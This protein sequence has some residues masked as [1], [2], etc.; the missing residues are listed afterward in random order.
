MV[1]TVRW[2]CFLCSYV[3]MLLLCCFGNLSALGSYSNIP[4]NI[5]LIISLTG[6][7][8][9][10][11]A[12]LALW[13]SRFLLFSFSLFY[14]VFFCLAVREQLAQ[15]VDPILEDADLLIQGYI[16]VWLFGLAFAICYSAVTMA[17]PNRLR[18]TGSFRG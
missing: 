10:S 17:S 9:I 11:V 6:A 5:A 18:V 7:V 3:A 13:H 14:S 15:A 12:F 2:I 4:L 16:V 8:W 1:T